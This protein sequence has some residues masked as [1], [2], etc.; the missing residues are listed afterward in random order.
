[1]VRSISVL[2]SAID[3][4][5]W[6]FRT[7]SI[8]GVCGT[9]AF[10]FGEPPFFFGAMVAAS[11]AALAASPAAGLWSAAQQTRAALAGEYLVNSLCFSPSS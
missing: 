10:F 9:A 2:F 7:S 1:M 5:I 6:Y 3:A 11:S 8:S 4:A